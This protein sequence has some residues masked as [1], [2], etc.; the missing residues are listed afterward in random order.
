MPVVQANLVVAQVA[1]LA[2]IGTSTADTTARS[3]WIVLR[4]IGQLEGTTVGANTQHQLIGGCTL[5]NPI[6]N[7]VLDSPLGCIESGLTVRSHGK[8]VGHHVDEVHLLRNVGDLVGAAGNALASAHS[9]A[10]LIA[11]GSETAI[12]YNKN[13]LH[14]YISICIE[15]TLPSARAAA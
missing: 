6:V 4:G 3:T 2:G 12:A 9:D 1:A 15:L 11:V 5:V 10:K 8:I 13:N 7:G 14:I